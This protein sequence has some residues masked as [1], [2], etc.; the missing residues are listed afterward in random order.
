L[1]WRLMRWFPE[2]SLRREY[3]RRIWRFIRARPDP[4]LAMLVLVKC[5]LHYHEYTMSRQMTSGTRV[6]N[7]F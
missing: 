2:A 5:A 1:Y 4:N 7:I 6:F 3:R